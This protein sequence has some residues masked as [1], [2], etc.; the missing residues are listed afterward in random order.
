ME[1]VFALPWYIV[2]AL[3]LTTG[4]DAQELKNARQFVSHRTVLPLMLSLDSAEL[5][6]FLDEEN[7]GMSCR[8][9]VWFK[10]KIVCR[11]DPLRSIPGEHYSRP[12]Q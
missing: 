2:Y 1:P 6:R 7:K 4:I 9:R 10:L 11:G 8:T 5:F 3:N 12:S